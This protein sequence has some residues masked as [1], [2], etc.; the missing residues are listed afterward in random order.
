MI[1]PEETPC[2]LCEGFPCIGV[3]KEGALVGVQDKDDVTMGVA[4]I[5]EEHCMAWGAQ[6]CEHCIR[7]CPIP[8]AIYQD[9]NRPLVDKDKCVGCG[10][11][12]NVC[13][14]VN[15]PIAIKVVLKQ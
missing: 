5:N 10:I 12:E 2:Y 15:Q 9:E 13:K 6:F 11:C 3:C 14:T 8:G 4:E 7:N 1:L